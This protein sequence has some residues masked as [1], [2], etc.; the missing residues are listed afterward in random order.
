[1]ECYG[2]GYR[3]ALTELFNTLKGVRAHLMREDAGARGVDV[4]HRLMNT[5]NDALERTS[6]R[7]Q[8]PTRE[9]NSKPES[10]HDGSGAGSA[11]EIGTVA[12]EVRGQVDSASGKEV[13]PGSD[14]RDLHEHDIENAKTS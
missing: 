3:D 9:G 2:Q 10:K 14:I 12:T 4:V 13:R 6:G 1:M 5:I 11:K 7:K 8:R